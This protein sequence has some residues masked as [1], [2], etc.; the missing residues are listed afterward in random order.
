MLAAGIQYDI[1]FY[2]PNIHPVKEYEIRKNENIRFAEKHGIR[3]IDADYDV[4]NWFERIKGLENEPSVVS[5]AHNVLICALSALHSMPTSMATT[6]SPA[7]WESRA[8]KT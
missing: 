5:A 3:M 8:G 6:R 1:F 2:N 4:D 7:R